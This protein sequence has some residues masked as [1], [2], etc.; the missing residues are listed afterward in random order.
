MI[1]IQ[2][3][4]NSVGSH[5]SSCPSHADNTIKF[6]KTLWLLMVSGTT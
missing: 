1:N 3:T 6:L 5:K 4:G 2:D